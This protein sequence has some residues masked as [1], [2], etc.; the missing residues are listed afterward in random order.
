MKI[1]DFMQKL[2]DKT[3][4]TSPNTLLEAAKDQLSN[5]LVL[6]IALD[7]SLYVSSSMEDKPDILYLIEQFKFD[8]L[9]GD[10]DLH[11]D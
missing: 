10:F 9:I 1:V 11:G 6:G 3:G 5:V 8:L 2:D 4:K 7:G